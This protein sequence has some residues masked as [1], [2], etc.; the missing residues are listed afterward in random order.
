MSVKLEKKIDET[1]DRLEKWL[2]VNWPEGL[3][4]LNAGATEKDFEKLDQ[5]FRGDIPVAFKYFLKRHNGQKPDSEAIFPMGG[6]LSVKEIIEEYKIWTKLLDDGDL[7]PNEGTSDASIRPV[8]F[9]EKW[10]PITASGAGDNLCL[11]TAPT[12]KG[13]IGQVLTLWHD[14]DVRDLVG[15][16]PFEDFF[17]SFVTDLETGVRK[18]SEDEG[19]I[20]TVD[21]DEIQEF[22]SEPFTEGST[23]K[24]EE[25]I[26]S[27]FAALIAENQLAP[28][29]V[30]KRISEAKKTAKTLSIR[31]NR[32]YYFILAIF[33]VSEDA[34]TVLNPKLIKLAGDPDEVVAE[35]FD[36]FQ[37]AFEEASSE[38][39]S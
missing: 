2:K 7:D 23:R 37:A 4:T 19:G 18:Y 5:T 13:T 3:K 1:W 24:I 30:K 29:E 34:S 33:F 25:E 27:D 10:L 26:L 17:D 14:D 11:D 16:G 21:L 12:K 8:W 39:E 32:S 6:L 35:I 15:T 31:T 36:E 22:M 28:P 20:A 38:E 9:H